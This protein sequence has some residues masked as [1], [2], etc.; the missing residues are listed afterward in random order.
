[1]ILSVVRKLNGMNRP[2]F[3]THALHWENGTA[4]TSMTKRNMRLYR[5]DTLHSTL[6]L[7]VVIDSSKTAAS[8]SFAKPVVY[9]TNQD[10]LTQFSSISSE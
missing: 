4:V 7:I 6:P 5:E 10:S 3:E 2:Y 1:M 8:A 9:P